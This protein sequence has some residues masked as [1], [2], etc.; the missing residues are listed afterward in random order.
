MGKKISAALLSL[1]T[2]LSTI[3]SVAAAEDS[4][5]ISVRYDE[6]ARKVVVAAPEGTEYSGADFEQVVGDDLSVHQPLTEK[7]V[8]LAFKV[9]GATGED[10]YDEVSITIPGLYEAGAGNEKPKVVPEIAEWY[11]A[12]TGSFQVMDSSKIVI[13]SEAL[14]YVGEE[15]Q[16]DLEDMTGRTLAILVG[17]KDMA[18]EGDFYFTL[19]S[20]DTMLGEE[21]YAMRIGSRVETEGISATGIYWA[22]RTILQTL[23]LSDDKNSMPEGEMRDYPKYQ[24]RGFVFD[25]ARKA[26]S[27]DMLKDVAKNMAW[28]KMNDLQVHLNDN[29]IFLED[30]Y[31]ASQPDANDGFQ[32]YTGFRLESSVKNA[33]N[34]SIASE[35]YHYS[36]AEFQEFIQEFRKIGMNIVPEIDVPAHAMAIT[37]VFPEYAVKKIKASNHRS[38]VDHLDISRPEVVEFTKT[39]FDD[40]TQSG[41][42]DS[43]T[44]IHVGA[45]EF[46]D[47]ATAYRE[48]LNTLLPYIKQTNTVRLWG[49]LT[50]IKDNKTEITEEAIKGSQINLWSKDW[51]DGLDM[52]ELG[53]DL[54]NTLDAYGY[55]VPNGNG[56]RGAY[57]DYVN[58]DVVFRDFMPNKVRRSNGVDVTLPAGDKQMLGGAYALWQDNIDTRACGLSEEDLFRSFF[59]GLGVYAEKTWANGQEKGS[60]AAIDAQMQKI[61]FAPNTNPYGRENSDDGI[62]A[63]YDFEA[64]TETDSSILGRDLTEMTGVNT[65]TE[66]GNT[67]L[68]LNGGSSYAEIP[69]CTLG[70]TEKKSLSFTLNLNE[71]VPGQILFEADAPYGTHDIRITENRKLGFTRELHEYE[72]DYELI[73][74]KTQEIQIVTGQQQ[75]S[76]YAD[77]IWIGNATGRFVNGGVVKKANLRN[78][79]LALPVQ[80]IGS[81]TNAVQGTIDNIQIKSEEELSNVIPA[82]RFVITSDN[83]NALRNEKEGPAYLAFDGNPATFWHSN[84]SPKQELPAAVTVDMGM[85]YEIEKMIYLPRQDG[86]NENGI[87]TAYTLEVST[88]GI[89]YQE[90]A[91]GMLAED[92]SGKTI[93]FDP[94]KARYVRFTATAGKNGFAS[95]SEISFCAA[96]QKEELQEQFSVCQNMKD[97]GYTEASW[98]TFQTALANAKKVLER[99]KA[100][101]KTVD[102]V[103]AVLQEAKEGLILKEI[104]LKPIEDEKKPPSGGKEEPQELPKKG[105]VHQIGKLKYKITESTKEKKAVTVTGAAKK[106]SGKLSIPGE[107]KIQ[108][109][110]YQVTAIADRAFRGNRK[111]KTLI[112]GANVTKIGKESFGGCKKL[113]NVTIT[114]IR[115]KN[116]GKHAF[117]GISGKAKIRVAKKKLAAYRKYFKKAKL[118]ARVK[119]VKK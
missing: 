105:S 103:L 14:R 95:A 26:V 106:V 40:Y 109:H 52:Y 104:P 102:T 93:S 112:I 43:N 24:V 88:D 10:S 76:L 34:I 94:V 18:K 48:F 30:F 4:S 60:V 81:K 51:S 57:Q 74:G 67:S 101:Q 69:L 16:K 89:Q 98:R 29:L 108:G 64:G 53:F 73:P 115:L 45:D 33:E 80:R 85:E 110:T 119:I 42:F 54:I 118:N 117:R 20:E 55:M 1:I 91:A 78:S 27:M 116:I 92:V 6:A 13:G 107:V 5:V 37:E 41:V 114:S 50:R 61:S 83:E 36:K 39:I 28:Y 56:T 87:I 32:G 46:E 23:K 21:G 17:T 66:N 65:V 111:L 63:A 113:K 15:F 68:L 8:R 99:E 7:E 11:S 79:S 62:Y 75:T 97:A 84:Y 3:S 19:A 25:V 22:T 90:T 70:S 2:A 12:S 44:I 9:E 35:D 71:V 96:T 100:S 38:L 49:G 47:S 58:K 82:E 72:F 31:N 77:G 86:G 59:D